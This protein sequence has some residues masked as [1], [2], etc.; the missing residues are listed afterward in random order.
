MAIHTNLVN[1]LRSSFLD[2]VCLRVRSRFAYSTYQPIQVSSNTWSNR[3]SNILGCHRRFV[4][5]RFTKI[6]QWSRQTKEKKLTE[7]TY[8]IMSLVTVLPLPIIPLRQCGVFRISGAQCRRRCR[9]RNAS[10][11][12]VY[13]IGLF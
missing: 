9:V 6:G 7:T 11:S 13:I 5:H 1:C 4:E 8:L 12:V 3:L 10:L 2:A